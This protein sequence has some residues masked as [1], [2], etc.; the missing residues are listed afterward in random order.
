VELIR[1]KASEHRWRMVALEIMSNQLELV[2]KAQLS[3][4]LPR[5]AIQFRGFTSLYPRAGF[6][7][8]R[9]CLPA[10]WPRSYFAAVGALFA[11]SVRRHTSAQDE[12][13]WR[14]ERVR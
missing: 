13:P 4:S 3:G 7:H 2:V 6:L 5:V 1:A 10:L 12:R 11:E 14:K 8:L 9:S